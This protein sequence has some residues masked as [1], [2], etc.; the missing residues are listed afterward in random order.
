MQ[1]IL[2]T[3]YYVHFQENAYRQLQ[4]YLTENFH[5]KV[6]ILVDENT[7]KYCLQPF[8]NKASMST[9]PEVIAIEAGESSKNIDTCTQLW[10]RL[11]DSGAD[12]KSLLINL[13]GG[14]ITDMGGFV[15]ATFK[16]GIKFI[17]IPTTLLS[18]VDASVGGKTG[19]DLGILKNQV[20]LFSNPEMVLIDM[21]FLQ[22]VSQREMRSGLAE[23]IKYGFTF[24]EHLWQTISTFNTVEIDRITPL[25]H[26]SVEI[27]NKV[28]LE[29]LLENDLRKSLNFGHTIGHAIESYFL[30]SAEKE[31]LTH[32]EA[33]AAGMVIECYF[34]SSIFNFPMAST[35]AL[36]TFVLDFYGKIDIGPDDVEPI[37]DLM[38]FDKKNVSGK[39]N[40]VLLESMEKCQLDIRVSPSLLREG[41]SFYQ[42]K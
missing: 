33:I 15:A 12:R 18:M 26:R 27:K 7:E 22:T 24:D 4:V 16:R 29:D 8:L 6:F 42:Q 30:E 38:K 19:V 5:S 9:V 13:G 2:S 40:F 41:I 28:V 1:S 17:N 10:N 25:V 34:S 23:I 32:G 39:V 35:D 20:G 36:K 31:T 11:S 21:D 14:V 3:N 37:L